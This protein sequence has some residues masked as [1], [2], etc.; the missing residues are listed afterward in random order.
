MG[1]LIRV[2][3]RL[4]ELAGTPHRPPSTSANEWKILDRTRTI[5]KL[6]AY[7]VGGKRPAQPYVCE[8]DLHAGADFRIAHLLE[9]PDGESRINFVLQ[10]DAGTPNCRRRPVKFKSV[11]GIVILAVPL[12]EE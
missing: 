10:H 12:I 2:S 4:Q 11:V 7:C 5:P 8:G 6:L 1:S 9:Q 3:L